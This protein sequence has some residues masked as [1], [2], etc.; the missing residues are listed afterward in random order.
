MN[1]VE[2]RIATSEEELGADLDEL[3]AFANQ[4]TARHASKGVVF[5][6]RLLG[7]DEDPATYEQLY[8]LVGNSMPQALRT[9]FNSSYDAFCTMGSPCIHTYFKDVDAREPVET[10]VRDFMRMLDEDISHY[11]STYSNVDT[12]K[13]DIL[14]EYARS[15]DSAA[16]SF[17][18]GSAKLY[19]EE[20][21]E[22]SHVP[23]YANNNDLQALRAE[24]DGLQSEYDE[25]L[26]LGTREQPSPSLV[27]INQRLDELRE[28][29]H[30]IEDDVFGLSSRIVELRYNPRATWRVREASRLLDAGDYKGAQAILSDSTRA[31][32]ADHAEELMKAGSRIIES[33]IESQ[34][35][36]AQESKLEEALLLYEKA[37]RVSEEHLVGTEVLIEYAELLQ[38]V[39]GRKDE[40]AYW[41]DA[42][43]RITSSMQTD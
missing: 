10:A 30:Q 22:L 34:R 27:Q 40:A 42:Y 7:E 1:L 12:I 18:D 41:S 16:I 38:N 3:R 4:L 26:A 2:I 14:M 15:T 39:N 21:L 31:M 37:C 17:R 13:L 25:A 24:L 6:V 43:K 33:W 8:V 9:E 36:L 29:L 35:H 20:A 32:E 23:L 11:W 28:Q 19:D 5:N